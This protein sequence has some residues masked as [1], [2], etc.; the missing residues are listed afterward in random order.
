MNWYKTASDRGYKYRNLPFAPL[1]IDKAFGTSGDFSTLIREIEDIM[2]S[3][4]S[5]RTFPRIITD[6]KM[7]AKA[8][9]DT[10]SFIAAIK[11]IEKCGPDGD[12]DDFQQALS[13]IQ[14]AFLGN[15]YHPGGNSNMRALMSNE[16]TVTMR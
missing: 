6:L 7:M 9:E 3:V 5:D 14:L 13:S 15:M 11:R 16:N 10:P 2:V 8:A 4:K 1:N 12:K